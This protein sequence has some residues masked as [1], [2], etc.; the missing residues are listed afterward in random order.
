VRPLGR[1]HPLGF[2]QSR[3]MITSARPSLPSQSHFLVVEPDP[4]FRLLLCVT[5]ADRFTDFHAVASFDEALPLLKKH[6][7]SAIIAEY[8]LPG[9]TGMALHEEARTRLPQVPFI[10]MC[11]GARVSVADLRFRFLAKPFGLGELG[12]ALDQIQAVGRSIG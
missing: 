7:F 8:H 11:G 12:E 2:G 1:K 3:R 10:L 6:S 4:L 5:L 9:G